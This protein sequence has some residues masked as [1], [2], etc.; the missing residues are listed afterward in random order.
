MVNKLIKTILINPPFLVQDRYGKDLKNFGAVSEPLG[1]AY[2]AANLE[3]NGYVV[4]IIDGPASALSI[5][6]I[7]DKL[8]SEAP[9]L[10]GITVLTPMFGV[11]KKLAQ[12][13]KEQLPQVKIVAGGVHATALPKEILNEIKELD[14]DCVGEGE[15]TIIELA[16]Y[17]SGDKKISEIDGLVYR[18]GTD[19]I[20]NRP[21]SF[22]M[23]LDKIPPPARHLL[24]MD[25]YSLTASRTKG[26]GYCPTLIIA[27][28]CPFN[29]YYCSHPFG[30]SFRHHSVDRIISEV[31]DL[32]D[33]YGINQMNLEA[34]TL[35]AD[36]K[37]LMDLC[38]GLIDAGISRKV[39]W[40]CES[41]VDTIDQEMLGKMKEAGCWQISYGVESGVP[42][43]L[44]IINKGETLEQF[45]KIF[46]LTQ[47]VGITIRGFFMLGLPT[48]TI[49]ESWQTINFAKK[50]NPLWAQFTITI[51][52]PGTPLFEM[53]KQKNKIR[54]F[55]WDCYN[56]WAGWAGKE[57]PYVADGRTIEELQ[58]LQKKALIAF[59]LR[60]KVF[61][62]FL[63]KINS[64]KTFNKYLL[65]FFVLVKNKFKL[66]G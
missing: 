5:E 45:E 55:D 41:R 31:K 54:S 46:K 34:D 52:Y 11:V 16:D 59:Y 19:I 39:K 1:I 17:L 21:R 44:E 7:V 49:E 4:K 28:G 3:K 8:K 53:L 9:D 47:Q 24:P 36:K 10:V 22:E 40:T 23:E 30:R 56:T 37:F 26:V 15:Y 33:H 29:C 61:F 65:G 48:E 51:P 35:T 38:Q 42:R 58:K 18:Q 2:I 66:A 60:P 25:K 12:K 63:I 50:L 13:I 64:F 57:I 27:R 43:L 6:E 32:I 20:V 14:Y 62:R